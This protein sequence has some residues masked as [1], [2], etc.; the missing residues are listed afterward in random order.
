MELK[1]LSEL[2]ASMDEANRMVDELALNT[3]LTLRNYENQHIL[4]TTLATVDGNTIA[5]LNAMYTR[6]LQLM[7]G[8][9]NVPLKGAMS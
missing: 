5:A 3:V 2:I 7:G 4:E 1:T 6:G 9:A 8:A